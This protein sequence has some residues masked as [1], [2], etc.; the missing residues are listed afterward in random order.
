MSTRTWRSWLPTLRRSARATKR[1]ENPDRTGMRPR[2]EALE[3]RLMPAAG[4]P[5]PD[6]VVVVVEENHSFNEILGAN[7]PAT[8]IRSLAGD[9]MAAVFQHS[10]GGASPS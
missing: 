5:T 2:L 10:Y 4:I 9:S 6:H 3:D 7:S 1:R 8:Y